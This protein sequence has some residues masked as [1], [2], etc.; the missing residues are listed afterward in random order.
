MADSLK[1]QVSISE[2]LS[3]SVAR[4][5]SFPDSCGTLLAEAYAGRKRQRVYDVDLRLSLEIGSMSRSKFAFLKLSRFTCLYVLLEEEHPVLCHFKTIWRLFAHN[6]SKSS[7]SSS[8]LIVFLPFAL[9][10]PLS[11]DGPPSLGAIYGWTFAAPDPSL[12]LMFSCESER[13]D[14]WLRRLRSCF[15]RITPSTPLESSE[16]SYSSGMT[17]GVFFF[18]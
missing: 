4:L 7:C 11:F 5:V 18:C 17:F 8:S 6:S 1:R 12:F 14:S 9:L 10:L 15:V 16:S 3:M 13:I 2:S